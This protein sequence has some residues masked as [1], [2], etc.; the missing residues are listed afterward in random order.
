METSLH[1]DL[2]NSFLLGCHYLN[3]C[4]LK[5]LS[6]RSTGAEKLSTVL[7]SHLNV[8]KNEIL[9]QSETKIF[10]ENESGFLIG[11]PVPKEIKSEAPQRSLIQKSFLFS[12]LNEAIVN[13]DYKIADRF[14]RG[15]TLTIIVS[16][17]G[18]FDLCGSSAVNHEKLIEDLKRNCSSPILPAR[19]LAPNYLQLNMWKNFYKYFSKI[20]LVLLMKHSK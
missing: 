18:L 3:K 14:D 16:V 17:I 12:V 8:L 5:C 20:M 4:V 1:L 10:W 9:I 15:D 7:T 11:T 2:V 19:W 6:G 13:K